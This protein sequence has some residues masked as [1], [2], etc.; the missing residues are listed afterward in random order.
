VGL[1]V[2]VLATIAAVRALDNYLP[3]AVVGEEH[4]WAA[5]LIIGLVFVI[6]GGVLWTRRHGEA[7]D[8]RS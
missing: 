1:A 2:L 3:D 4:M 8:R 6:A 7:E 5:Y